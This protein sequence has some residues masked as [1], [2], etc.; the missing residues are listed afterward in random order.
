MRV[1]LKNRTSLALLAFWIAFPLWAGEGEYGITVKN[2]E[3]SR[4]GE[5]YV[6]NAD[7]D[8][9]LSYR[10]I[11]ALKNSVALYWN[12]EFTLQEHRSLLWNKTLVDKKIRFRVQHH[13]L[14]NSYKVRNES[15]GTTFN[16]ATLEEA[17]ERLSS[18]RNLPVVETTKIADDADYVAALKIHFDRDALPLPL[19]PVAY[20]HPQWYLSSDWY[21]WTLT[22]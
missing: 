20:M 4:S 16:A 5:D 13:A 2:A 21:S 19:R 9:K 18:L 10:A 14:M 15:S 3:L 7:I 1:S 11:D 6:L 17:L 12:Y 8:F 22:K